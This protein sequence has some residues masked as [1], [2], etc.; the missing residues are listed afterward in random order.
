VFGEKVGN[1]EKITEWS[2]TMMEENRWF[3]DYNDACEHS[4]G[5]SYDSKVS[6]ECEFARC[7]LAFVAAARFGHG[8]CPE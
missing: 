5:D 7:H 3:D 1:K 4:Q 8:D 6:A 2:K